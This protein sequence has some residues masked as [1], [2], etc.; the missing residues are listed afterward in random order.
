[1]I[2]TIQRFKMRKLVVVVGF[3]V[4]ERRR[5]GEIALYL[6]FKVHKK[7]NCFVY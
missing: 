5:T 3:G 4:V 6:L 2:D 1:M 7:R